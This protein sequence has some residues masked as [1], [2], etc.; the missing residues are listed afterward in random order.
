MPSTIAAIDVGSN[1][2]RLAIARVMSGGT[3]EVVHLAR[4]PVRLGHDV[5]ATNR[6][7][8]ETIKAALIAFRRF[9]ELLNKHSVNR[10]RA[11]ATSAVR[12]AENGDRLAAQISRRYGI[13]LT[14]I[15]PEEEARL[16]HLAVKDRVRLGGK[17]A[18]LVDIGGG[19][20]EISLATA[21][22]IVSTDSFAM[23]SVRLLRVLDQRGMTSTR[24]NHLVA[25]YIDVSKQRLKDELGMK[26]VHLCVGTG[27][28][29][30]SIGEVRRS[31]FKKNSAARITSEELQS[32]SRRLQTMSVEERV[33]QLRLRPDR[34]DVI[35]PAAMVLNRIVQ[36]AG[37]SEVL[38]PGVGVR[39]GVLRDLVEEILHPG[40]HLD[41]KQVISSALQLGRK[42]SFDEQ[43]GISVSRI[44]LQIFDQTQSIHRL[45]QESRMILEVA[46]LLHDIGHFVEVSNHHKHTFYLL[47]TGPI[48]G[49]SRLQLKIAANVARYHRKSRPN[50][51]HESFSSLSAKHRALVTTLV[52][53][54]RV[55][56][57]AD[58]Q[59]A[60]CIQNVELSLKRSRIVLRLKGKGDMLLAKWALEK[61]KDLFEEVF[62]ELVVEE[63]PL[64]RAAGARG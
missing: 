20:V 24:F 21:N 55:A 31:L 3:Y 49:M 8:P 48:V 30:E 38:I 57:A 35:S 41:R 5:F 51:D 12:E 1:A 6:I 34:A 14:V 28:S 15:D 64:T 33:R 40:E 2:I 56:D 32:I 4:E 25:Q 27:G 58:R 17:V 10:F 16:V 13:G 42:Y 61:R 11:V 60:G 7:S 53:I 23:G 37:V 63:A 18:L 19:S 29:V 36:Q 43:H 45:D 46:A 22:G 26:R 54:L 50:T 62:G 47:Q 59:H 44:A 9:R 52:S 39:E